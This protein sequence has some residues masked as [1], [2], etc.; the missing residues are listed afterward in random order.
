MVHDTLK[1]YSMLIP[2]VAILVW[3]VWVFDQGVYR[4]EIGDLDK[5]DWTVIEGQQVR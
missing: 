1:R 5:N 2:F 4:V 3:L